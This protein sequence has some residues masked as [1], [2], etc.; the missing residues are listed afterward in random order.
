MAT[1]V[2]RLGYA[3]LLI[4][5]LAAFDTFACSCRPHV[6]QE[7][8]DNTATIYFARLVA[9]KEIE[10]SA[11]DVLG[12]YEVTFKVTEVLKGSEKTGDTRGLVF[13]HCAVPLMIGDEYVVFERESGTTTR[14]WG[15]DWF[16]RFNWKKDEARK[17][18]IRVAARR[19][20]VH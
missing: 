6:L 20:P 11:S 18:E 12:H 13:L 15:S 5:Q 10:P 4:C 9:A 1:N 19:R 8:V 14:C 2:L 7:D 3:V 17:N 16:D